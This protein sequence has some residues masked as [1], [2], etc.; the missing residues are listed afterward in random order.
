MARCPR[1]G[2]TAGGS[3]C[4]GDGLPREPAPRAAFQ[5]H[6]VARRGRRRRR[7]LRQQ[8]RRQQYKTMRRQPPPPRT[9]ARISYFGPAADEVVIDAREL[10]QFGVVSP[11]AVAQV[12]E[13]RCPDRRSGCAHGRHGPCFAARRTKQPARRAS[14]RDGVQ[15][16]SRIK[17]QVPGRQLDPMRAVIVFDDQ[18]AAVI[19]LRLGQ[20]QR[21]RQ[22]GA[23]ARAASNDRRAPRCRRERRNAVRRR[24][25]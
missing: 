24:N 14:P 18:F 4:G 10:D 12:P 22:I 23:D 17:H 13:L 25:G 9:G 15:A 1:S 6:T 11:H 3:G 20:K 5:R 7:C 8:R 16:G 2:R 19:F 21:H